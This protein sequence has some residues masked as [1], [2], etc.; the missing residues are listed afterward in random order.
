MGPGGTRTVL[1]LKYVVCIKQFP[2]NIVSGEKF[3]RKGGS[4]EGHRLLSPRKETL[5]FINPDRRGFFLW[6]FNQPEP[7][8][9][10]TPKKA[11]T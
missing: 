10:I 3:Y 9:T 1:R 11:R 7:L 4:L 5:T 2:M 8:K 6:L